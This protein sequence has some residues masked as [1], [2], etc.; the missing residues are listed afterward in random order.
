MNKNQQ[1]DDLLENTSNHPIKV[2][3]GYKRQGWALKTLKI[4]VMI[5]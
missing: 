3:G 5:P 1:K 2:I 4:R